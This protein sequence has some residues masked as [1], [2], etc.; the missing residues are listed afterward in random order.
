MNGL[1]ARSPAEHAAAVARLLPGPPQA[2]DE[3]IGDTGVVGMDMALDVREHYGDGWQVVHPAGFLDRRLPARAWREL[4]ALRVVAAA[5]VGTRAASLRSEIRR[6][7]LRYPTPAAQED[8]VGW[9]VPLPLEELVISNT[10]ARGFGGLAALTRLRR[11]WLSASTLDAPA[12]SLGPLG[13]RSLRLDSVTGRVGDLSAM[14]GLRRFEISYAR[15][16]ELE[17]FRCLATEVRIGHGVDAEQTARLLAGLPNLRDL[18][19][20]DSDRPPDL[21]GVP[22]LHTLRFERPGFPDLAGMPTHIRRLYVRFGGLQ[23]LVGVDRVAGLQVLGLY[24]CRRL[25]SLD[26]LANHPSV[27]VIDLRGVGGLTSASSLDGLK[28]LTAVAIAG[29]GLNAHQLPARIRDRSP[30]SMQV[31]MDVLE[32]T[33]KAVRPAAPH[34]ASGRALVESADLDAI[35]VGVDALVEHGEIDKAMPPTAYRRP[36]PDVEGVFDFVVPEGHLVAKGRGYSSAPAARFERHARQAMLA[37]CGPRYDALRGEV[38]SLRIDGGDDRVDLRP[39]LALPNLRDLVIRDASEIRGLEALADLPL[40]RLRLFTCPPVPVLPR[41]LELLDVATMAPQ[42]VAPVPPGV[43]ASAPCLASLRTQTPLQ[44][45]WLPDLQEVPNL[46]RLSCS[47]VPGPH[48][49]LHTLRLERADLLADGDIVALAT[50]P[51]LQRLSIQGWP[52]ARS[53]P[54]LEHLDL[55]TL[56]LGL[57]A[58]RRGPTHQIQLGDLPHVER[59][60]VTSAEGFLDV[61]V[62][63]APGLRHL[64][65]SGAPWSMFGLRLETYFASAGQLGDLPAETW[66]G[67]KVF[68]LQGRSNVRPFF[69]PSGASHLSSRGLF[70]ATEHGR[71]GWIQVL[72]PESDPRTWPQER[73]A[74]LPAELRVC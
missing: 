43:L 67:L 54:P 14:A 46:A 25:Q 57:E 64:Q 34:P 51:K 22:T 61:H 58:A 24:Y 12:E 49:T 48:P 30:T 38:T 72:L 2:F 50:L 37:R 11:L 68:I 60:A 40:A 16:V 63:F 73:G 71:S 42:G 55:R 18:E 4:A 56:Q 3:A 39:L 21:S 74:R 36:E 28:E 47:A 1:L 52:A 31:D 69:L 62:G 17:G 15:N 44:L 33:P 41:T 10:D 65:C 26:A 32:R 45:S 66:A 70:D 19:I 6:V 5:P 9:L 13:L 59:L 23:S 27:A 35:D 20:D 53:L 8:D 29:S 7:L